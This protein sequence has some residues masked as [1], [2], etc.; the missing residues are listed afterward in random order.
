[1]GP[2]QVL[3][4]SRNPAWRGIAATVRVPELT[5]S[6]S[7]ELLRRLAPEL[8][9]AE[10]NRVTEAV[11][12]LPLAVEQAGS[13]LADTGMAV[14][15]YLRLLAE[16]THDVLNHDPGGTYPESV[17]A[18]W[19]VAFDRLA[20]DDPTALDLLT[21]VAWCGPEP[22]PLSLLTDH[23]NALPGQLQ[24]VATDPLVLARCTAILHRR[25]MATV[26]PHS[27]QLHRV[28]AALL[29][30]RS[31]KSDATATAG[32][33]AAVVRLLDETLPG[34]LRSAWPIWRQLA[35]HVLAV[36]GHDDA[37]NIVAADA[38]RLL[39]SVASYLQDRGEPQAALAA[40]ERAYNVRHHRFGDEHPDTLSSAS[41][42][43][44]V[45]WWLGDYQ[46]S[47][48][49]HA[50]TL[51]RRQRIMG[52]D[53]PATLSSARNLGLALYS[54]GDYREARQLQA[55]T[56]ARSRRILGEDHRDTLFSAFLLGVALWSLGDYQ[57]A[58]QLQ[59]DTLTRSRR[60]L[61]EDDSLTLRSATL[62][63]VALWSLGDYQQ[64]RQLHTDALARYRRV[65][66]DDHP[67][68]L[69]S[70]NLLGVALEALGE[71]EQARQLQ[72]DA[73]TRSCRILGTDHRDT[74]RTASFLGL[75]LRGLGK[76]RQ[77]RRLQNDTL[78]RLRQVLGDD[79]PDTLISASRLAAD[80]RELG[81]HQQAR[82]LQNDTL[83]RSRRVLGDDHP[84]TLIS[85]SRLSAD[86][87]ALGEYQQARALDEDT[88]T[89]R[90]RVLG[91]DHPDTLIS[92]NNLAADLRALGEPEETD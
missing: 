71:H 19:A 53:D 25:G 16:R 13:L 60:T 11:G 55:D 87:R 14:D 65:F 47:R 10:A 59:A 76:H 32:W 20:A 74:L 91:D 67:D 39:D 5:R 4:T 44:A 61:G 45:L 88:L 7:I 18:S 35:P 51:V 70:A 41:H 81:E 1:M 62:L 80:L 46:Q 15:N 52:E 9:E 50:D 21:L 12:D 54:L 68:T 8:T 23:P 42:L 34:A 37:L 28:P 79:H 92:A 83:I 69:R 17:A 27:I 24:Q 84:D 89:R 43:G 30:A 48:Q 26:S 64:A 36:A 56:L 86:L 49:L 78:T 22:V 82:Q 3:I 73:F 72:N 31:Q 58:R 75:T 90:R 77:A 57:Q 2:G 6:E 66:G 63:G 85:A 33:A 40:F 29:R 38:T